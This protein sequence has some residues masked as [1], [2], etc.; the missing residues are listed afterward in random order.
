MRV[1]LDVEVNGSKERIV[2]ELFDKAVP[3]TCDNFLHL[4]IGDK[5]ASG[6]SL[7]FKGSNFHRVI[8]G[9]MLQ[10]GDFTRGDGTGG[11][12]IY[13][14]KFDDENFDLKHD[15][16]GLLSMANSG[17]NT[18]GSQ[19]FI[20]TVPTPHLNGK[21]VVFGK[22]VKG[23]STVRKIENCEKGDSDKPVRD[24]TIVDCGELA[25]GEDDGIVAAADGDIWPDFIEDNATK[26]EDDPEAFLEIATKIKL[27]GATYLKSSL[28]SA[29]ERGFVTSQEK[30]M[31]AISY[32]EAID[33]TPEDSKDL[34]LDFKKKFISLKVFKA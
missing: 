3:M 9:F 32:L 20:T 24:I 18:N 28:N 27:I 34:S 33:P 8:K 29:D 17:P 2:I 31:K 7:T 23:M 26:P 13:G 16:A 4:C 14:N 30:F 15:R 5:K 10:G 6:L 22:V 11:I 12:S 19:F 25:E 1:Y 21:H